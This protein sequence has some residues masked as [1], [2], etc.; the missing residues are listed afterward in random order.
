MD[1]RSLARSLTLV[2]AAAT[3]CRSQSIGGC[4]VLPSGNVWNTPIDQLSVDSKST[5]YV[6]T[7][8]AGKPLHADFSI[9]FV[10]VFGAQAKVPVAFQYAAES[11]PGP[12]PVP[13]DAPIE[14]GAQSKGDRHVLVVDKDHCSPR[15][16]GVKGTHVVV[17]GASW[18]EGP[19]AVASV[20]FDGTAAAVL[21][22]SADQINAIVPDSVAAQSTTDLVSVSIAG[23]EAPL[24][25]AS[26]AAGLLRVSAIV[27]NSIPT[28]LASVVLT[29][30][31]VPSRPDVVLAIP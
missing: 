6:E 13:P 29:V 7:I 28:G 1:R 26:V 23:K 20:A 17:N 27:P 24:L 21:F 22:A 25:S 8:G 10:V 30:N 15:S 14:G 31:G 2:L 11:D 12:Y 19:V 16:G 5:A 3:L 18:S 9:P 4:R